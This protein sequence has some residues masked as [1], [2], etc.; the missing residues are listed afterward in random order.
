[1]KNTIHCQNIFTEIYTSY[2]YKQTVMET[3]VLVKLVNSVAVAFEISMGKTHCSP[4]RKLGN[5]QNGSEQLKNNYILF[6]IVICETMFPDLRT[7]G[8]H[9]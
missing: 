6:P 8:K 7:L 4:Y 2:I 1:M 9:D 3:W 5:W